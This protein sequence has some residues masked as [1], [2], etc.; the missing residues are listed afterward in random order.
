MRDV[1]PTL[2]L[3]VKRSLGLAGVLLL[4]AGVG[5]GAF[6]AEAAPVIDRL[7]PG[8][9]TRGTRVTVYGSGF[10]ASQ[11]ASTVTFGGEEA[12]RY[13][14]WDDS[15]IEV[16]L[17]RNLP[18]G[19]HAVVVTV[20]ETAS[21]AVD[22][23]L[24]QIL[25]IHCNTQ[26]M[27][28]P[29]GT[30]NVEVFRDGPTDADLTVA[31]TYG[32]TAT[33]G[34]DY[35]GPAEVTIL[36]GQETVAMDL[37][38]VDDS[39]EE[40]EERVLITGS[41]AG[42]IDGNCQIRL[43]DD[44]DSGGQEAPWIGEVGPD[45][46]DVGTNVTISG[47]NFGLSQGTSSVEFNGTAAP[48]RFWSETQ[49]E[50][51]VPEGATTGDV[52]VTVGGQ[53]SNGV[54]FT[55]IEP[56]PTI[57]RLEPDTGEAGTHVRIR[58]RNFGAVQ[59]TSSV[60][61]NGTPATP[62][63][64]SDT[65]VEVEVPAA[66]TSGP[67]VVTVGGVAS[68]GV[69]FAVTGVK[70]EPTVL[71]IEE[72]GTG[73]YTVVL[74]S[75]PA[76][77]VRVSM[78]TGTGSALSIDILPVFTVSNWDE[79]QTVT[80]RAGEDDDDQDETETITHRTASA[81][82]DYH[83]LAVDGVEVTIEDDDA[84][85]GVRVEPTA[86]T[87]EEGETGSYTV[88]LRQAP[89]AAV[90]VTPAAGGDLTAD[91]PSL[92][93]TTAGWDTPQTVT[94]TAGEDD[95]AS[96]E[97]ETVTH[98]VASTDSAYSGIA[99]DGVRVTIADDEG[100]GG[101]GGTEELTVS[102]TRLRITEGNMGKY[103]VVLN[104]EPSGEVRVEV[105][106][107]A[108][109]DLTVNPT[110]LT[111][112]AADWDTP[113][114]VMVEAGHDTDL[115]DEVESITHTITK[116]DTGVSSL[117][118][119]Y[120]LTSG[121]GL[122][123][124]TREYVYLGGR[125]VAI[126]EGSA[127]SLP[128][129]VIV[130]IDDDDDPDTP[131][132]PALTNN[133]RLKEGHTGAYTLE[134]GAQPT[135]DVMITAM[136][137]EKGA[138]GVADV[139]VRPTSLTFTAADWDTPQWVTVSVGQD[140]D[141]AGETETIEH[142]AT[143]GDARY[144]GIEIA[145]VN[146]VIEDRNLSNIPTGTLTAS[147]SFC[148]IL[149][150]QTNCP[151]TLRW[152]SENTTAVQ[153]RRGNPEEILVR[154]GSP[155]SSFNFTG[156]EEGENVFYLYDYSSGSRGR[157]LGPSVSVTGVKERGIDPTSGPVGTVVTISG[158]G[159]GTVAGTVSFG[160]TV[161]VSTSWSDTEI[162]FEVPQ[163][164][165]LGANTV[166]VT[167]AGQS[168]SATVGTF[169]VTPPGPTGSISASPNPCII[170]AGD[171]TC[172]T[173]ITWD[174]MNTTAVRVWV[175]NE[176]QTPFGYVGPL[177]AFTT[178][179]STSD[180]MQATIKEGPRFRHT[181]YVYD[182]SSGSR[183]D[184]LG[185]PVSVSGTPEDP[186]PLTC[187]ADPMT[188]DPGEKSTL[189]WTTDGATSVSIDQEIGN[190]TPVA[191]GTVMVMPMETTTYTFT[192]TL[193]G[194]T[195]TCAV[196]VRVRDASPTCDSFTAT[197]A[198]ICS[199]GSSTLSWRTS[200]ADSVT[201]DQGIGPVTPVAG[202]SETVSPTTTTTYTLTA[203]NT[204]GS[205]TCTATVTVGDPPTASISANRTTFN[206]GQPFTLSWN[207]TNA[208]SASIDQGVGTVTPNASDSRTLTPSE[209][210]HT[211]TI[212]ASKAACSDATDSVT[213]TVRP[214]PTNPS[215]TASPNPCKIL[216]GSNTCTTTIS[217]SATGTN[218]TLVEVDHMTR[219]FA[220]SG[221]TGSQD[222]A[223]IQEA[224]QHSYTF[225]LYDYNNRIKGALLDSVGVTG[226]RLDPP[227]I[228][229]FTATPSSITRG[230]G[231]NLEWDTTGADTVTLTGHG[232][233]EG[234]GNRTVVPWEVGDHRYTLTAKN[235]AGQVTETETV[236]VSLPPA[237]VI[238]SMSPSQG[239]PDS[240]TTI[241]GTNFSTTEGSVSFGGSSA[242]INSWGTTAV[243]VQV[244]GH[245][246][247]GQ[248]TVNLTVLGQTSNDLTFT[249]T[250][251]PVQRDCDEEDE[252][253]E[254]EEEEC[255]E[256]EEDCPEKDGGDGDGNSGSSP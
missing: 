150:G 192:A 80:V 26:S 104:K 24:Q 3:R 10:G 75:Q 72:G 5:G 79:P 69:A 68:N 109:G 205:D 184:L 203:T 131:G 168:T 215:I 207:T 17:P 230:D 1:T 210:T 243:S 22:F 254:E 39:V 87:I 52:V 81:D 209:G 155:N 225:E 70:V 137:S 102:T 117:R 247:R 188:I 41:A 251:D 19:T 100:T 167:V 249:V 146:V 105:S 11:G 180:S 149:T 4:M 147:S 194:G 16:R 241:Y 175:R 56:V 135:A 25:G 120:A 227:T 250:G 173:T 153:L 76:S 46:G 196:T 158:S 152:T 256:D 191:G 35:T 95:D 197:P 88:V 122:P 171:T 218:G 232:T 174:S 60:T 236:T 238:T 78:F 206:E 116:T 159:F 51:L 136:V 43:E 64:W 127:V 101:P 216:P 172:T 32:G 83:D 239:V 214:K 162:V 212:T 29:G 138:D 129:S 14:Q 195:A 252:D 12:R 50:A 58:G 133:L 163:D 183:G 23:T 134:L 89:S 235:D 30:G 144:D 156:V 224:P 160:G 199:G 54:A 65:T 44:S 98:A 108:G 222:A 193:T 161:V 115:A 244:P 84:G 211:Y 97:T 226:M 96:D 111:F 177:T 77:A 201:I 123:D 28:E 125:L 253:C 178:S 110:L 2:S 245:L 154:S 128:A 118:S 189:R 157:Q 73:S 57:V 62:F 85:A 42:Y 213:V 223:W 48:P 185:Q 139:S 132:V 130:T 63:G 61:F 92:T 143:S 255:D 198:N 67:V 240:Q 217:W 33:P 53:A 242:E 59:G 94:L 187:S 6:K 71:T 208:G 119:A 237:P 107:P 113:Q 228:D 36:A 103:T 18:T 169:T 142:T 124:P 31:I 148:T 233:V 219:A 15:R 229:S 91:P 74:K 190:V 248:V 164:A 47:T 99:V 121:D 40:G 13:Y 93:F 126:E 90:T 82:P 204:S 165:T 20:G 182:H 186:P 114:E 66:A 145:S 106:A 8:E 140:S 21:N 38:V 170:A 45:T 220:T 9:A 221:A 202:G 234:D 200:D 55:V 7:S 141:T 34:R 179:D 112:T 166:E 86:L 151:V 27:S 37:S 181:F 246:G 231:S 176:E 49:I